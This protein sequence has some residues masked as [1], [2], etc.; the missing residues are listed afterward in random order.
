VEGLVAS[1][2][3]AKVNVAGGRHVRRRSGRLFVE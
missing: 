3:R 2:R 1:T